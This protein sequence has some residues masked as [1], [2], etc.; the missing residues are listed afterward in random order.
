MNFP[1]ANEAES[2]HPRGMFSALSD[3]AS[4]IA[5]ALLGLAVGAGWIVVILSPNSSYDG[6]DSTSRADTQIK[7]LLKD[8]C[9]PITLVLLAAG[10]FAILGRS[11]IAGA[12]AFLAAFGFYSNRWTLAPKK[13]GSTPP[14]VRTRRKDQQRLAM[15]FSLV[16]LLTA[17][18]ALVLAVLGI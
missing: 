14:G 7:R 9:I 6:N 18:I 11:W 8:S 4:D 16:F 17:A 5:I 2:G 12:A 13:R 1:R 3:F 10:A 15:G